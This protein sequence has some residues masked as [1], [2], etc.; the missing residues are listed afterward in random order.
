MPIDDI[1]R[2]I[3]SWIICGKMWIWPSQMMIKESNYLELVFMQKHQKMS[4]LW[5]WITYF[6][7]LYNNNVLFIFRSVKNHDFFFVKPFTT[8]RHKK[9]PSRNHIL[10]VLFFF[11]CAKNREIFS[12]NHSPQ[13]VY[14]S[15]IYNKKYCYIWTKNRRIVTKISG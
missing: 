13:F 12:Q 8:I 2:N 15:S 3:Y 4:I 7:Y 11:K 10:L 9:K 6:L 5:F 1:Q 14:F